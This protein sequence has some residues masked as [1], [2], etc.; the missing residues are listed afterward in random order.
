[1]ASSSLDWISAH[2]RLG[3]AVLLYVVRPSNRDIFKLDN[4]M[5]WRLP[6]LSSPIDAQQF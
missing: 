6:G 5:S 3:R 1:M 2:G 4:R